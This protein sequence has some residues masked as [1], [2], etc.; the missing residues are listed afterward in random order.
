M[1]PKQQLGSFINKTSVYVG[2]ENKKMDKLLTLP[3]KTEKDII[4]MGGGTKSEPT[5]LTW[6]IFGSAALGFKINKVKIKALEHQFDST[7]KF[8]FNVNVR[9]P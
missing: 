4:I 1:Q 6:K 5:T 2:R 8:Y 7:I 9:D 3:D